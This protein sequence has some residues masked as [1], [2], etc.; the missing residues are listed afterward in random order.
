MADLEAHYERLLSSV[1][2]FN[3]FKDQTLILGL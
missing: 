2:A 1:A 3:L